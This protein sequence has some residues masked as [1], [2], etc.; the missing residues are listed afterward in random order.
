MQLFDE[1][2][3]KVAQVDQMPGNGSTRPAAWQP[4]LLLADQY[5]FSLPADLPAGRLST[6]FRMVLEGERLDWEDGQDSHVLTEIR[7]TETG[8]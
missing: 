8:S 1:Q 5:E 3:N 4:G 2:G 6:D 7:V